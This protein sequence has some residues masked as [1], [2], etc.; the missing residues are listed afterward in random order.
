MEVYAH[1]RADAQMDN[2]QTLQDHSEAV[3]GLCEIFYCPFANIKHGRLPGKAFSH[4]YAR[5]GWTSDVQLER[6][7][8]VFLRSLKF[9]LSNKNPFFKLSHSMNFILHFIW[10]YDTLTFVMTQ[11]SHLKR[12]F[13]V[14]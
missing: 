6:L 14:M 11:N 7:L 5:G 8:H 3:A 4:H 10:H 13:C 9:Q 12:G 1:S 2:W